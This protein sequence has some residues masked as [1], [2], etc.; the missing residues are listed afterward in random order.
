MTGYAC[1][2]IR[3]FGGPKSDRRCE[4]KA[5]FCVFLSEQPVPAI[6]RGGAR[7]KLPLTVAA[8]R[9]ICHVVALSGGGGGDGDLWSRQIKWAGG[10]LPRP[11]CQDSLAILASDEEWVVGSPRCFP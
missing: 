2:C 10:F 8:D 1:F 5:I 7:G 9:M 11:R 4:R 3:P 6:P